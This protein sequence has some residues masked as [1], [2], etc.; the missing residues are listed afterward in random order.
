M[1]TD[2]TKTILLGKLGAPKLASYPISICHP[3]CQQYIKLGPR[4]TSFRQY[5]VDIQRSFEAM[6]LFLPTCHL[7]CCEPWV[8]IVV[9]LMWVPTITKLWHHLKGCGMLLF[10]FLHLRS[11]YT[12]T[13]SSHDA[14]MVYL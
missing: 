2:D 10:N 4:N 5:D 11:C 12:I 13:L 14:S 7:E 6:V 9:L 8:K 3:Q 1:E